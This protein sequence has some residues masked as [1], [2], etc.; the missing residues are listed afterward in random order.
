MKRWRVLLLAA[1]LC[2]VLLPA[3]RSISGGHARAEEPEMQ[4]AVSGGEVLPG[5]AVIVW[6]IV[7][8]SGLCSI[9]VTDAAGNSVAAVAVDRPAEQGYNSLYWNG[10]WEGVAVEQGEWIMRLEMNGRTAETPVRIGRMIPFL[11]SPALEEDR[12]TVGKRTAV[13]FWATEAG[14]VTLTAGGEGHRLEEKFSAEAGENLVSFE[15]ALPPGNHP[16]TIVLRR[17]DGMASS[18]AEL[19]LTVEDSPVPFTPAGEGYGED[20]TLNAWTVPMDITDED[21]VWQA[22][23]APVTVL[24]DGK[25]KAQVRQVVLR[26][27]PAGDSEGVGTV[28]LA[29]QGVHVLEK[30]A[31]WSKIECYSSSFHDSPILNWNTLVQGWIETKYLKTVIPNQEMGLVVDKLTQRMYIFREGGLY[32][33]LLVSTGLANAKQPYNE[34]RSGEFLLVSKVGGFYSDNMYCPRALRFND[35]DLLHEVPY[36]EKNGIVDYSLTEPKLGT[37]ASHGCIR[38]Q[39]KLNPDG[40]SQAWLYDNYRMNTKILIWEDWQGRQ[41]PVPEDGETFWYNARRN[42]YYHSADNCRLMGTRTPQQIGY[43]ELSERGQKLKAC[44]AC[45]PVMKKEKLLEFNALYAPGGDHDPVMTAARA[46]CPKKRKG[47]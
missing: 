17:E 7:P 44:P 45:G 40:L 2:A 29:S 33:T 18:P 36:I 31:E 21:A 19:S 27:E 12:V 34:T 15:A 47:R 41:I 35:G 1:L 28:T 13:S 10:T 39:R 16:V 9:T 37:R 38:V 4:I 43:A 23:T 20:Y 6:F 32:S 42:D 22:L 14:E 30:G 26:R 3:N 24:D 46:D 8:E 25:D 5:Q 11:I